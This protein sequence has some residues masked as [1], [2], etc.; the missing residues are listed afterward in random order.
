M[1]L[2]RWRRPTPLDHPDR[3]RTGSIPGHLDLR[4]FVE[5]RDAVALT[6]DDSLSE[7]SHEP[8]DLPGL[9]RLSLELRE[10]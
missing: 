9:L 2:D 5:D 4:F 7:F 6:D 10:K 1:D 3:N 8:V